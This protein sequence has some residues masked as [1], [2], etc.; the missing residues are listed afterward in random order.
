MMLSFKED[1]RITAIVSAE[2]SVDD[3]EVRF[4][5]GH[6]VVGLKSILES[7]Y[8]QN[9]DLDG[10]YIQ[11]KE[12]LRSY[13]VHFPKLSNINV[14][15]A[16]LLG[17][18]GVKAVFYEN[19]AINEHDINQNIYYTADD[20]GKDIIAFLRN[21]IALGTVYYAE[22]TSNFDDFGDMD[23]VVNSDAN[24]WINNER[25]ITI[26]TWNYRYTNFD[27]FKLFRT[28]DGRVT[29]SEE[30]RP[31]VTAYVLAVRSIGDML[32]S[33]REPAVF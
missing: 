2:S 13:T 11:A 28:D 1:V 27:D 33:I 12:E 14:M 29:V 30:L 3:I 20:I 5:T 10:S 18:M 4:N 6:S 16:V 32:N 7:I 9:A 23:I 21:E 22:S 19:A 8:M 15:I 31:L 25:G 24:D 17:K 26:N